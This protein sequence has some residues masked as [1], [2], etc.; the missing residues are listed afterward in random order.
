MILINSSSVLPFRN[1]PGIN[2][3]NID[4]LVPGHHVVAF[5]IW[6]ESVFQRLKKLSE[7]ERH[8]PL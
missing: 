3:V 4:K 5:D 2:L 8:H 1:I 6:I 7:A